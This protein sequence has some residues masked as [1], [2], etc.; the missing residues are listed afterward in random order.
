M[1]YEL[2]SMTWANIKMVGGA[3]G[4]RYSFLHVSPVRKQ[5]SQQRKCA[6]ANYEARIDGDG[7]EAVFRWENLGFVSH[8]R[9]K[10]LVQKI[11]AETI[12][13]HNLNLFS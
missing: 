11:D 9:H 6:V 1:N 3:D 7:D 8:L 12:Y 4:C 5:I 13:R 10:T 2:R